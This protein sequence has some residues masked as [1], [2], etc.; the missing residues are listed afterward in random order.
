MDMFKLNTHELAVKLYDTSLVCKGATLASKF[1][2][3]S[4]CLVLR[5]CAIFEGAQLGG[6]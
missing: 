3:S 2:I 6:F 1:P 5:K 4:V